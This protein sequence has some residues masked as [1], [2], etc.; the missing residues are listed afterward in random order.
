MSRKGRSENKE[1]KTQKKA[2]ET[3]KKTFANHLVITQSDNPEAKWF[4]VHTYSGQEGRVMVALKQRA[5]TMKLTDRILEIVI[6]TQEQ[7]Q[8]RSG[9][10]QQVTEKIFPGYILVKMILDDNSW[11]TVR[12]TQGV[13]GFVGVG[14]KPT[15]ISDEEVA[16]IQKFMNQDAPKYRAKFTT[17]E[18]V[19]IVDGPFAE[20]LGSIESIDEERG[21]VKVLVSIFG[22]ETP[23]ELDFL[24]IKKL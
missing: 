13:T 4:V 8:I 15:P 9:R 18:A 14:D 10:K 21:K 1:S 20:F 17:G 22:R 19:K 2:E 24:Q 16:S 7:I 12:T 6:P 3:I 5:E 23:V 11:L